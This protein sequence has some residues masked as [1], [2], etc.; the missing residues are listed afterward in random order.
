MNTD[1]LHI[2]TSA[3]LI[4]GVNESQPIP[5]LCGVK[6]LRTRADFPVDTSRP[7]CEPC[8]KKSN[9]AAVS[10]DPLNEANF[11]GSRTYS[12]GATASWLYTDKEDVEPT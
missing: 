2:V 12:I 4:F 3:G 9:G 6:I 1:P 7:I 10:S 8:S 5:T 11:G